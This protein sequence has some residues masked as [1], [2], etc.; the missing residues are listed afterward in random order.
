[1]TMSLNVFQMWKIKNKVAFPIL[2][3]GAILVLNVYYIIDLMD[4]IDTFI[5]NY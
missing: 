1:M 5:P 2:V 4:S 3:F